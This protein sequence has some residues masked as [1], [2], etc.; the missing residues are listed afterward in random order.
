MIKDSICVTTA[1]GGMNFNCDCI[2]HLDSNDRELKNGVMKAISKT[3]ELQFKSVAFSV[4]AVTEMGFTLTQ[5]AD[6]FSQGIHQMQKTYVEINIVCSSQE[7]VTE[8]VSMLENNICSYERGLRMN[9]LS[10]P[11][12]ALRSA[13][14]IKVMLEST[15]SMKVFAKNDAIANTAISELQK[16]LHKDFI[17][18]PFDDVNIK[19][20]SEDEI[21]EIQ[22][23][24]MEMAVEIEINRNIGRIKIIGLQINVT[25]AMVEVKNILRRSCEI[26]FAKDHARF[27]SGMVQ[28][29][30]LEVDS[31]GEKLVDYP[32]EISLK[33]EEAVRGRK[34]K[35]EFF[36]KYGE[37][38]IVDFSTYEEYMDKDPTDYVKVIRKIKLT[39]MFFL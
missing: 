20:L 18:F 6:I 19:F 24:Q 17:Q 32:A 16:L 13:R 11:K 7:L 10:R 23:T 29:C 3:E 38:Y 33:L 12:N 26:R 4:K 1:G 2:I 36:Y 15:I 8:F 30:F 37:K 28:W 5:V 35:V 21:N 34:Q 14:K 22:N 9:F 27:V 39:G 25:S 31:D